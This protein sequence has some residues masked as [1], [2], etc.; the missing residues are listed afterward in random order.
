MNQKIV[1]IEIDETG[2]T[3]LDLEGFHGNGCS[4]VAAEF[5]G[6]DK[7]V[8]STLKREFYEAIPQKVQVQK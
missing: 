7:I 4:K 2:N 1:T 6:S 5:T 3:S 8:K